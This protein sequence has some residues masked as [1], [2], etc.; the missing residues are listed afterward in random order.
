MSKEGIMTYRRTN[1]K[2]SRFLH[3]KGGVK[4]CA[5]EGAVDKD[6]KPA[7]PYGIYLYVTNV[8]RVGKIM[9][10]CRYFEQEGEIYMGYRQPKGYRALWDDVYIPMDIATRVADEIFKLTGV[11][12]EV[13]LPEET[14]RADRDE[15][16]KARERQLMGGAA[17]MK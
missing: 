10:I 16:K 14:L 9:H 7:Q 4:I 2:M 3:G 1:D 6:G 17:W 15:A 11:A 5:N 13:N 12:K 8:P